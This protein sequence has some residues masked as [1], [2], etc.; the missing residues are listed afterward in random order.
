MS[1]FGVAITPSIHHSVCLPDDISFPPNLDV[2]DGHAARFGNS[3][4]ELSGRGLWGEGLHCTNIKLN[5]VPGSNLV[6]GTG[7]NLK[8]RLLLLSVL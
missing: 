6:P 5:L 7:L 4:D 1:V 8:K 3:S 2:N